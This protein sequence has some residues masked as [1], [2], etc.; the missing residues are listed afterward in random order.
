MF[1]WSSESQHYV[2]RHLL[3]D[4]VKEGQT[5]ANGMDPLKYPS[6]VLCLAESVL[7]TQRTEEAIKSNNLPGTLKHL[8]RQLD[9]F[10]SVNLEDD[11][12]GEVK[13]DRFY[14]QFLFVRVYTHQ[15]TSKY[16]DTFFCVE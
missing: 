5:S 1:L 13:I 12:S 9:A 4:C 14:L 2:F 10:T 11:G 15:S 3:V 6:Q 8:R 16:L 7:F